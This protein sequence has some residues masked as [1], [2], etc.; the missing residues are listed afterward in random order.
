MFHTLGRSWRPMTEHDY[1][2]SDKMMDYWTNFVKFGNP[3]GKG[4]D[5]PWKN[6]TADDP[7][8]EELK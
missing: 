5:G 7:Y 1:E 4:V 2:L 3:N 8:I 6:S